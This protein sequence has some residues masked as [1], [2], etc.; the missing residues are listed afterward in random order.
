MAWRL[1]P[2]V[3]VLFLTAVLSIGLAAAIWRRRRVRGA[4]ILFAATIAIAEWTFAA[5]VEAAVIDTGQKMLWSQIEYLGMV[6]AVPL[7]LLFVL[8][9]YNRWSW[10]TPIRIGLLWL[11]P[12]IAVVLAWT[13]DFHHLVWPSVARGDEALNILVYGHG[14]GFWAIVSYSYLVVGLIVL[15]VAREF[16]RQTPPFRHQGAA[17][18]IASICPALAG[19]AYFFD[20]TPIHGLDWTPIGCAA[21]ISILSWSVFGLRFLNLVPVARELLV[22]QL[23]DGVIVLDPG[24]LVLDANPAARELLDADETAFGRPWQQF[25][26][27]GSVEQLGALISDSGSGAPQASQRPRSAGAGRSAGAARSVAATRPAGLVLEFG[28]QLDGLRRGVCHLDVRASAL[29]EGTVFAGW[30][31]TLHDVTRQR[32]DERL[33][34]SLTHDLEAQVQ[35]RTS[36][37]RDSIVQLEEEVA[38]RRRAEQMLREMERSLAERVAAQGKKLAALHEVMVLAGRSSDSADLQARALR[39][40]LAVVGADAGG[41]HLLQPDGALRLAHSAGLPGSAV[42]ALA[43]VPAGWMTSHRPCR[44]SGR[45]DCEEAGGISGFA[46]GHGSAIHLQGR[47]IGALSVFWASPRDIAADDSALLNALAEQLGIVIEG[48]RLHQLGEQEAVYRERRRLARDLHDS[49][50]QSLH[51]LVLE[52][53][54]AANRLEQ[55]RFDRLGASLVG[56]STKAQQAIR[57]MRLLLFE[58]RLA[59]LED[60]NLV[61]ALRTRL[62]TVEQRAGIDV[63]FSAPAYP[64]WPKSVEPD[65]YCIA[66]EALNN[67]LKHARHHSVDVTLTSGA[68]WIEL[69]VADDGL[70]FASATQRRGGLGLL[71]MTER[72]ERLGSKIEIESNADGGTRVRVRV[73]E[74]AASRQEAI[75]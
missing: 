29:I 1:L 44:A 50:T 33:L 42:Q 34:A 74:P 67:A 39:L 51:S 62:E 73:Q 49:V 46:V 5:A 14:P 70:G 61:E 40:I 15:F 16:V 22:E 37:L 23:Q 71:S 25:G 17:I 18:L 35:S 8:R 27:L 55:G 64:T 75:L 21:M 53:D 24:G 48:A 54:T 20:L 57:E 69:E 56:L 31:V 19:I 10:V 6:N 36:E 68:G 52:A 3:T 60:V 66:M 41:L 13:N 43:T 38:E 4:L 11:I 26:R 32:Q 30:L 7:V 28:V 58:L 45:P 63:R 47:V 59:P 2:H 65:L 12:M 9:Y 72:A